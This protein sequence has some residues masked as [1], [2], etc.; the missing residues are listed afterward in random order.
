MKKEVINL[1]SLNF[2]CNTNNFV[3]LSDNY[4]QRIEKYYKGSKL[5]DDI[6]LR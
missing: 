3:V 1:V 5:T 6:K 4:N 2:I